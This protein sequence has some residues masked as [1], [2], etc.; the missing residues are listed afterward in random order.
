VNARGHGV[1]ITSHTLSKGV[2][3]SG[4]CCNINYLA[5]LP[6][7]GQH[8][9]STN[10]QET[11]GYPPG[12]STWAARRDRAPKAANWPS[13]PP[14]L[15]A[16]ALAGPAQENFALGQNRDLAL[17]LCPSP[18]RR[19]PL[20]DLPTIVLGGFAAELANR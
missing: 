12:S 10:A 8:Q 19:R 13:G 18:L 9:D 1:N 4:T 11:M 20:I 5:V 2:L 17:R 6:W 3:M 16:L 14:R 15:T 7:L